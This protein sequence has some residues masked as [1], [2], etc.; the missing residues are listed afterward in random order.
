MIY[1]RDLFNI[2]ETHLILCTNASP[3]TQ[4]QLYNLLRKYPPPFHLAMDIFKD[5]CFQIWVNTNPVQ[6][7]G[8]ANSIWNLFP[9]S[10]LYILNTRDVGSF[11]YW[12]Y[13]PNFDFDKTD[14]RKDVEYMVTAPLQAI[15]RIEAE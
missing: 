13:P 7:I 15:E 8:L 14:W 4:A 1:R 5:K 12:F 9:C 6:A 11:S 10:E 2:S 3:L